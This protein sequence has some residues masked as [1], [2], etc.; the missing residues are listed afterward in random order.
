MKRG[1]K[2][3]PEGDSPQQGRLLPGNKEGVRRETSTPS[4]Q[5][6]LTRRQFL[7]YSAGAGVAAGI[8]SDF[9]ERFVVDRKDRLRRQQTEQR[10]YL[11]NF[12]HM[13][14]SAHDLI[15]VAGTKRVALQQTTAR[16]LSVLRGRHPI[17][18]VVPDEDL[19]H[20]VTLDMP[21]QAIQLCYIQRIVR[22]AT[23]GSWDMAHVFYH[24]PTSALMHA[25]RRRRRL[26][27]EAAAASSPQGGLG[28]RR[29]WKPTDPRW[30]TMVPVPVKWARYGISPEDRAAFSDPVGEDTLKD[31]TDQATALVAGHPELTSGDPDSA[32][33]IQNNIIA[34]QP[35]TQTL[36]DVMDAQGPP[37]ASGGWAIQT[38]LIDEDTNQ[39]F[40]NSM[41]QIQYVPVWSD[42]T[43]QFAGQAMTPALTT[44][45]N[46]T[47]LGTNITD[48][49]PETVSTGLTD[50]P[51]NGAV[52]TLHDGMPTV[53]QSDTAAVLQDGVFSYQFNNQSPDKG[54]SVEVVSVDS[55]RNVTIQVKNWYVR[56]LGLYV[57]YLDGN[58]QPIPLSNIESEINT[59]GYFPLWPF[60]NGD[61]DA[62]IGV[63]NP[64]WVVYGI[65]VQTTTI[66]RTFP[67][68]EE[69]VSVLFL[70]GGLGLGDNPYPST[71]T[72]GQT[73][74][75]II[76]FACPGL[77]LAL[78]AFAAQ[79]TMTMNLQNASTIV[80][81]LQTLVQ[82][83]QAVFLQVEY[84]S[85]TALIRLG[86][87]VGQKLL[88]PSAGQFMTLVAKSISEATAEEA[89]TDAI[90][91]VGFAL[92]AMAAFGLVAQLAET[93][94]EVL[95]SPNTYVGE[96]T[97]THDIEMT[98]NHDPTDP[99][100]FPASATTYTLTATFD[101]GTPY[102]LTNDLPGTTVTTP[103]TATFM[104]VPYGGKVTV[105]VGFYSDT[106][107]LAG[108][109]SVGPVDNT[110]SNGPLALSITIT[111]N[112]VP[113]RPDTGYS[114][115][116]L[117]V[118]DANG[119]HQWQAAAA[120]ATPAT[121]EG[122]CESADGQLCEWTGITISTVNAAVGYAWE[123]Y[124][125]K[126]TNCATGAISQLHQFANL[127]ITQNPQ[128][129][130]LFS[131]CGFSG[132]VRIVYDLLGQK[133]WN[134]YLDPT[135][136]NN[137]IRQIRLSGGTADFDGPDSNLAWGRFQF[138]SDAMLLHPAGRAISINEALNKIEVITLPDAAVAD[139]DAPLSQVYSGTGV[140]EGLLSG[141]THAALDP[142]GTILILETRNNRIQAFDLGANP[143][144]KFTQ[145]AYYV[146]LIDTP[147]AYLDLAVEYT[148][149]LYVLSY[150]GQPGS[151]LFRLDIYT[152]EGECL[153]RTTGFNAASLTVNYWRDVFALNYNV[154]KLPDGTLPERTEPSVSHWIPSTSS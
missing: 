29:N 8:P 152:P 97:F 53:D 2:T 147:T 59:N 39:P 138:V 6:G 24:L 14:T 100:G 17:L 37:T 103:L 99:A 118:L 26:A 11:F 72:P 66:K 21:A 68:P 131:G 86:V 89:A 141:P 43:N 104:G 94:T 105:S 7:T 36:G 115:K 88:L 25:Q 42:E 101:S 113:L 153:A 75:F 98:V 132:V 121:P 60:G 46:D 114:H 142:D 44:A 102:T 47:T 87:A 10:T 50:E 154:L 143:V 74:T 130:Y 1:K 106:G 116:E 70:A 32:A 148:G 30:D 34:T 64:E 13:D 117:I 125:S 4:S 84:D 109:G 133:D 15:L 22:S 31:S 73:M 151:L 78:G 149:Y 80:W 12:S 95:L 57:R 110:S 51:V 136:N 20:I 111:E 27:A 62:F 112:L 19:T 146:P 129:E 123:A 126:V 45:K 120:P 67:I 33:H 28:L 55:N 135:N 5:G 65:P 69:A 92:S 91:F 77:Y 140:R 134:F 119:N 3:N 71:I 23:D 63:I 58:G 81:V 128:S 54:Y 139:A 9:F 41:N 49:D 38:P 61:Y 122:Q 124:N 85:S 40:L 144:P 127:S 52:W 82:L 83:F 56:Y 145:G 16:N 79:G 35:Q 90:P 137:L 48:V 150:T 107:W 18:N 76:D 93:S 96:L 108:Q